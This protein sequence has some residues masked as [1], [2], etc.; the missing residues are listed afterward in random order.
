MTRRHGLCARSAVYAVTS[1]K[2]A[3]SAPNANNIKLDSQKASP[4]CNTP[5]VARC[6]GT[7][8][9]S[10]FSEHRVLG[11]NL[12]N[13]KKRGESANSMQPLEI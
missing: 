13:S 4:S 12:V 7:A 11:K 9:C 6:G 1:L 3:T 2:G 10:R 5:Q 8:D